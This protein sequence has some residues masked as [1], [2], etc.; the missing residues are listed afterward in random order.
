MSVLLTLTRIVQ[1]A[2][3]TE[4]PAEQV[5]LIV[6]GIQREM[7]VDV[8]SLYLA[9][10]NGDM[11][12]V[13]S[14]GLGSA[15][16]GEATIP[17]GRGLVGLVAS[18]RH[19]LNLIDPGAHPAYHYLPGSEEE[20]YRTFFG[21]PLVRA[22]NVVGV[23]VV[24]RREPV[25]LT[26]EEAAFL[27]TLSTQLA[28]VVA[29]WRDWYDEDELV[30]RRF[31]GIKGSPGIGI[32]RVYTCSDFELFNVVDGHCDDPAE[33]SRQWRNLLGR[34]RNEVREEQHALGDSVSREV[35]GIFDAYQMLLADSALQ[36]HVED[37]IRQGLD[38]ATALKWA[39]QHYAELF[40]AMDDPY[41]RTRYEDIHHLGN[42]LYTAWRQDGDQ[43]SGL[44]PGPLVLVGS[45]VSVSDIAAIP[46]E[47]LE[48]IV[49][50]QGSA[51]SHTAVLANALGVP[52]VLGLGD[53]KGIENGADILVDGNQAR[54]ILNP[55][56]VLL[57]EYRQIAEGERHLKGR[58]A[59]LRDLPAVTLD[60]ARVKLYANSGLT[61]DISPGLANG[62]EGLGLYRTEI[63]FMI[64]QT[65]PS[66]DEQ[67]LLYRHVMEAYQG[68]PVHMRTLDI[69]ADKPLPYFPIE[70]ENPVLGWRGIRFC[71]DNTALLM[72]QLR[73][74]LRAAEGIGNQRILL[75]MV[76][77]ARELKQFHQILNA[78]LQQLE[79]EGQAVQRPQ[80]GIMVEV[81]A[82]I[83][84]L[85]KWREH[86]DF[87]SIG[88]NDLSQYITAVDRNNARVSAAYDHLHPSV[89]E[90]IRRITRT[91]DELDLPLSLCGEM[92]SDPAAVVLLVGMG[93]RTLSLSA[94]QLP[95]IKWLIRAIDTAD[96]QRLVQD[97]LALDDS[98]DIRALVSAYLTEL[99][100]PGLTR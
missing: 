94:A 13:A 55:E 29:N 24:Q 46:R 6:A 1:A 21:V 61:A 5:E 10:D 18:S 36:G 20:Q 77:A 68:K 3:E 78:A 43:R 64:S 98:N 33:T 84:Q 38:L 60:G 27:V 48:A 51:L 15:A 35:A 53:I 8:S 85:P 37:G 79:D 88:S 97:A 52:A 25:K 92:S 89:L 72:T 49:C 26:E 39:I 73:A 63:P 12:L 83:S 50:F 40:L 93:I 99:A 95:R 42:R 76:S 59:E 82:A 31:R 91:A 86:I 45:Q 100:L 75:P 65:F 74:M 56:P 41:L 4:R 69:G 28:M 22:G 34:V 58:L 90:E 66:E 2:A 9:D 30:S 7:T 11:A 57:E 16:V 44:P 32:G 71:L 14:R 17:A 62:A 80:V 23:L 87:V 47:Q 54:V 70:E 19:A 96:A 81:P 67:Y